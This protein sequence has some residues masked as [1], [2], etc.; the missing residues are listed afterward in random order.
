MQT[1]EQRLDQL[2]K[3][4]KRLTVALTLMAVVICAVVTR[5][6][7]KGD[8]DGYFDTVTTKDGY[9]D[10][11]TTREVEVIDKA[12]KT[13]IS[14]RPIYYDKAIEVFNKAGNK[15]VGLG[16]DGI[17]D[18]LIYTNSMKGERLVQLATTLSGNGKVSVW[19][20]DSQNDYRSRSLSPGP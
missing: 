6:P 11:V 13:V 8:K 1:T 4:N 12:G 15:V 5:L 19:P 17:G 16:M 9:F 20:V 18:G 2:E 3:R 7:A 14:L 10:T